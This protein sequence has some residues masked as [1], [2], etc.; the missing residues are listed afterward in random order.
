MSFIA[1]ILNKSQSRILD[2]VNKTKKCDQPYGAALKKEE[3]KSQSRILDGVN[4]TKKCD[5]P[6]GAALKRINR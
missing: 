5:Q 2:G 4:K 3:R 6:F 1:I